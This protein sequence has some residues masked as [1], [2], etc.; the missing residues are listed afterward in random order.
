M[1]QLNFR[2]KLRIRQEKTKSLLCVGLDL[3]PEKIPTHLITPGPFNS[4]LATDMAYWAMRI[5]DA[6]APYTSMYKPQR[7]Y[8]EAFPGGAEA[9]QMVITYIE[10]TY[11]D[12][13]VFTDC[14]RGDIDRTQACYRIAQFDI[15]GTEGMNFSPYMGKDC[16]Q[17][18][19]DK[20]HIG[21]GIVGLC[22][23]SNP[24]AREVQDQ[25]LENGDFYWEFMAKTILK[26]SEELNISE[27]SGLVMAA[28]YEFP[29]KSGNIYSQHLFRVREL[30]GDKLWLLIPGVGTQGGY[31]KQTVKAA[32]T[33]YGSMAINSSSGIVFASMGEDFAEKAAE[34]ARLL[35]VDMADALEIPKF[36]RVSESLI[37]P[38]DPLATL[39]N[40]EGYYCSR[41]NPDGSFVGPLVAYAGLYDDGQ[42]GKK[43][44]VG[45]EYFNFAKLEENPIGR[46]AIAALIANNMRQKE[47]KTTVIAGAPMGGILLGGELGRQ[48]GCR[49]IFAEKKVTALADSASG[50]KEESILEV[51]RHDIHPG[52]LVTIGEDVNNNYSTTEKMQ[53]I[54][55]SNGAK[56]VAIISAFNRS[57]KEEWNGIP[58]VSARYIP[59]EQFQ[60]DDPKVAELIAAGNII[61]KPKQQWPLLKEAMEEPTT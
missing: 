20:D 30:V 58:V 16:M 32:F 60:Q 47:I 26:W 46:T 25:K 15:D 10:R 36:E 51:L 55:E 22:Y 53:E 13:P 6:T 35:Y 27:N 37:I 61:W 34:Q 56:L 3:L 50:K 43:N 33:G 39:K 14:K 19:V 29:K 11:P 17:F 4:H 57:G 59:T 12:I 9:L 31:V 41:K 23:T 7:A 38:N 42:G 49:T 1:K 28:A 21:R 45:A 18:L 24:S 8:W 48:L 52:D 5:V 40:F 44:K 54:I 2:E